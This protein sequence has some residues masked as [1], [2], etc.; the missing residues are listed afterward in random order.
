[1]V[2]AAKTP[3]LPLHPQPLRPQTDPA[4][5]RGSSAHSQV[6]EP[7]P[8]AFA[9]ALMFT[10]PRSNSS[11]LLKVVC[12][13]S[14]KASLHLKSSQGQ[15]DTRLREEILDVMNFLCFA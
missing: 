14:G 9:Y 13:V 4:L 10:Y 7:D 3:R 8:N 5:H 11:F 2:R 6:N 12:Y 1:M 15:A